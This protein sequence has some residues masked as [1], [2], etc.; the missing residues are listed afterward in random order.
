MTFV[1]LSV[2]TLLLLVAATSAI[3]LAEGVLDW[4]REAWTGWDY[5]VFVVVAL[6][7]AASLAGTVAALAQVS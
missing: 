1:W 5:F 2:A 4:L 3:V 6:V 7:T